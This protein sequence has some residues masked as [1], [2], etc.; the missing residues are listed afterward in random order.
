[1]NALSVYDSE[2]GSEEET[3]DCSS[4]DRNCSN[5]RD[6][7][8]LKRNTSDIG[9]SQD[10]ESSEPKNK[11]IKTGET[12][13][14]VE[15]P[16]T[17]FWQ[18]IENKNVTIYSLPNQNKDN[19]AESSNKMGLESQCK[20]NK[21]DNHVHN[22]EQFN[23]NLSSIQNHWMHPTR[24]KSEL[25]L[26]QQSQS[27]TVQKRKLYYLHSKIT[28]CLYKK[29]K[30]Y[31]P[32]KL[33]QE[34]FAHEG[35]INK[36][37][38][39]IPNYSHLFLSASM[40]TTVKI[41]NIWSQL[42]PCL[43]VINVHSKAV[44]DA[45]WSI[46]GKKILSCSY[47]RKA[48]VTDVES[49]KVVANFEHGSYVSCG[50]FHPVCPDIVLTGGNNSVQAWDCRSPH[51][52]CRE[53]T[54]KD[55]YGQVQDV[56]FSPDGQQFYSC[57]DLVSRDSAD[58]NIMIWDYSTGVVLSNQ[59]YQERYTCVK[60]KLHPL[61]GH[62]LAQSQGNYIALF[63]TNKP[64]KMNKSKRF[65]GH[66][67]HGYKIG[68]DITPDGSTVYSGSSDGKIYCYNYHT[69]KQFRTISTSL[70]VC[71]DIDFH[72][73]LPSTLVCCGWNGTIQ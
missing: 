29:S 42:N 39:N 24:P 38:W 53:Y 66:K 36:V 43:K 41:W 60:L 11:I 62:L 71:M 51:S 23:P 28:Q 70:D 10:K 73:V 67:L 5:S 25:K 13:E 35:A 65:E 63:S 20:R 4:L 45:E 54:Y 50:K 68:F 22:I 3:D 32:V 57:N 15:L 37:K 18:K 2:S 9:D 44:K 21:V 8:C 55:K 61:E 6:Y 46:C 33:E 52:P 59:V 14:S 58:R 56:L 30:N 47:D 17:E 34:L 19:T 31:S 26:F 1:M 64:Y 72:P 40:D 48:I 49:D 12:L 7:F 69:G 27:D 16:N